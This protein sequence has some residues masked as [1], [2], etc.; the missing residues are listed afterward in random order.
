MLDRRI[1]ENGSS[2]QMIA[3]HGF[4]VFRNISKIRRGI[5]EEDLLQ[6]IPDMLDAN[7]V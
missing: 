6:Q 3:G 5:I 7:E 4:S 2:I 1:C